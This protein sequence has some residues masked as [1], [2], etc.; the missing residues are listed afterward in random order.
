[1]TTRVAAAF[2]SFLGGE[3]GAKLH[4]RDFGELLENLAG[5][6]RVSLDGRQFPEIRGRTAALERSAR[7]CA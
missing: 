7:R 4:R 1:M 6:R 5:P 3:G 2:V